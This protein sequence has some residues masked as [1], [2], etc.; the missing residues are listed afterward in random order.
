MKMQGKSIRILSLVMF[1]IGILL[2]AAYSA[3]AV[4]ADLEASLFDPSI[5]AEEPIK[6][7]KCPVLITPRESGIITATFSNP[8]DRAVLR[9]VRAHISYG[10][11]TLIREVSTQFTLEPGGQQKLEWEVGAEDAAWRRVVLVRVNVLRNWPLPSQTGSCG[12]IVMNVP[13]LTGNQFSTLL[14]VLSVLGIAIGI[15]L[16]IRR[17][18]ST[19]EL[20]PDISKAMM[21][22]G[23]LMLGIMIVSA[24]G[25][26]MMGGLLLIFALIFAVSFITW[27]VAKRS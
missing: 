14:V 17:G 3:G 2:G 4:W 7:L 25:S 22:L 26:W 11:A 13:G 18:K 21:I 12:V 27:A 5:G 15:F 6:T 23:A 19:A 16:W 20:A 24:R 8:S 9:T 10:F 1:A